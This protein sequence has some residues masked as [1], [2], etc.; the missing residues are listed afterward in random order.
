MT[1]EQGAIL[2]L[3]LYNSGTRMKDAAKQ[4]SLDTGLNK[5]ELYDAALKLKEE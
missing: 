1:L 3:E 5:N 4:V 2:V